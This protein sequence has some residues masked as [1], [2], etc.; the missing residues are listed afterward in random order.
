MAETKKAPL[1]GDQLYIGTPNGVVICV[2]G[3]RDGLHA[4]RFWHAHSAGAFPLRSFGDMA[5]SL[6]EYFNAIQFP[7][8][9]TN[10]RHFR[11]AAPHEAH[12]SAERLLSDGE[13]LEKRGEL[14]TFILRVQQRENS[15]WQGRLTWEEKNSTRSFRSLIGLLQL[16]ESAIRRAAEEKEGA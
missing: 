11:E 7:R 6:E 16:L 5:L 3:L 13:L 8:A 12:I 14:A 15:T 1:E 2:D 4:G 9:A 10:D